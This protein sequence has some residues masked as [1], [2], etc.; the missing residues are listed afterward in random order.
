MQYILRYLYLS[1]GC[2]D[3]SSR[4]P[5]SCREAGILAFMRAFSGVDIVQYAYVG[6]ARMTYNVV[7]V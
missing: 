7:S 3:Y 2:L 5:L 6:I 4:A 1:L